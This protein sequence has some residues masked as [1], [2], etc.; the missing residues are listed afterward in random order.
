MSGE[1][2]ERLRRQAEQATEAEMRRLQETGELRHLYGQ[3]LR[4]D[5]DP[6]WLVAKV[7]KEQGFSHP[8]IERA[9][10][11]DEPRHTAEEVARRLGNRRERLARLGE[12]C[13]SEMA[14][15]FNASREE[16]LDEYR[17]AL[18]ALNNAI[19]DYNLQVPD[20]LQQRPV[21]LENAVQRLADDVPPL[22]PSPQSR[23]SSSSGFLRHLFRRRAER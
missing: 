21:L 17:T 16:A 5:D 8:L 6:D 2:A 20:A 12:R 11:L 23:P 15:G 18:R 19:R 3:P 1:R 13:T 22:H 14:T 10:D 4:L 7:L 9:R